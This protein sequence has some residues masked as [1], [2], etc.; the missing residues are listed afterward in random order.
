MNTLPK[1]M[2]TA[3]KAALRPY[4]SRSARHGTALSL[5]KRRQKVQ[6]TDMPNQVRD[7]VW[8]PHRAI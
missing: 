7:Q 1:V 6:I 2:Q 8:K 5:R 4:Q 3:V